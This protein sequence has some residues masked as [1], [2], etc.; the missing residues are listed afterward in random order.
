MFKNREEAGEK[1]AQRFKEELSEDDKR[2]ALILAI[3]RG[4]VAIG[5]KISQSLNLPLDCL[6][7]KKIPAPG[8]E[9]LA[10]GAVGDGGTVVWEEELVER[11]NVPLEYKQ[12]IVKN[13]ISELE[14]KKEDF[15][16]GK[17]AP[18]IKGKIVIIADD[19]VA[20]GATMK[21]AIAVA[22]SFIPKE[23]IVAV[24]VVSPDTLSDLKELADRVVYLEAP[25]MFFSV[26]QFYE[27]FDQIPDEE[28]VRILN[29]K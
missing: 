10:I 22:K 27:S 11:L 16:T 25:E 23:I 12:E 14:K 29:S 24:P 3:P 9:E 15:R 5:A 26:G 8:D 4:G 28:V 13:K 21:V 17:P 19:G 2:N 6:I 7:I 1:L 20:T 18:D